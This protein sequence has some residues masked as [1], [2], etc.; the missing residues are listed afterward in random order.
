ME[1]A[2]QTEALSFGRTYQTEDLERMVDK[3]LDL[4]D[5][6]DLQTSNEVAVYNVH[7]LLQNIADYAEK[8]G[9]KLGQ[10]EIQLMQESARAMADMSVRTQGVENPQEYLRS[11]AELV[12]ESI[13]GTNH[14]KNSM[15]LQKGN[16]GDYRFGTDVQ[17]QLQGEDRDE[18]RYL[19]E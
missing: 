1:P 8:M 18:T 2:K 19:E 14:A 6:G 16:F 7:N 9:E 12:D 17:K 13:V 15:N 11:V 4:F 3:T 5:S 10:R